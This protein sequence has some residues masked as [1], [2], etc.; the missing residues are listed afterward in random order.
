[1]NHFL[2][3]SSLALLACTLVTGC[4]TERPMDLS[5]DLADGGA[6]DADE[7]EGE[8]LPVSTSCE[9]HGL[10]SC[11]GLDPNSCVADPS[12][13][14]SCIEGD[15]A[16]CFAEPVSCADVDRVACPDGDSAVCVDDLGDCD[17]LP[18][19]CIDVDGGDAVLWVYDTEVSTKD[20]SCEDR[21][22]A[23]WWKNVD[24]TN[25]WNAF[26]VTVPQLQN[27]NPQDLRW[28]FEADYCSQHPYP[29]GTAVHGVLGF[30]SCRVWES[31]QAQV[32]GGIVDHS[33]SS[34]DPAV[35]NYFGCKLDL[36]LAVDA[37]TKAM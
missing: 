32:N 28:A 36:A 24:V 6:L 22:L 33:A 15:D 37:T 23:S 35:I 1:M 13:C 14:R 16:N 18:D 11:P 2:K 3:I 27:L 7:P 4:V 19:T 8:C 34:A 29:S 12:E 26:L 5:S 17:D 30:P 25:D 9:Q 20:L 31:P 10:F 21:G